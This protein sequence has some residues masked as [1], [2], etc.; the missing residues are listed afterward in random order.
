M[1]ICSE[2]EHLQA[3]FLTLMLVT[4]SEDIWKIS[5]QIDLGFQ[6]AT[7]KLVLLTATS[8]VGVGVCKVTRGDIY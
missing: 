7:Y 4:L 5:T 3:R 6:T 8:L 1:S 2:K